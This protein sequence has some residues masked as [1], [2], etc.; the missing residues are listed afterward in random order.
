MVA[1]SGEKTFEV[2]TV[3]L[4]ASCFRYDLLVA[5]FGRCPKPHQG[6][7]FPGPS[8]FLA[9]RNAT[10]EKCGITINAIAA[11]VIL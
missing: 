11:M 9:C 6:T 1:M 7:K 8:V 5:I 10:N 3:E 2:R 4:G